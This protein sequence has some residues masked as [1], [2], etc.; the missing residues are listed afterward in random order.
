MTLGLP[1]LPSK[2]EDDIRVGKRLVLAAVFGL[3]S[4]GVLIGVL[5]MKFLAL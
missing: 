5:V 2:L 3:I 4:V 1:P